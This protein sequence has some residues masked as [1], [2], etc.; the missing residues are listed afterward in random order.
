MHAG[1]RQ[2]KE[3]KEKKDVKRNE[4]AKE[5]EGETKTVNQI[6]VLLYK[7]RRSETQLKYEWK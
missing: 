7:G 1:K 5:E 2:K 3:K 4:A 6:Y